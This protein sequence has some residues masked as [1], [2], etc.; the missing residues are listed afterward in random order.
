MSKITEAITTLPADKSKIYESSKITAH[1]LDG[2][3]AM[4]GIVEGIRTGYL[5]NLH[6]TKEPNGTFI[7]H[8]TLDEDNF[9]EVKD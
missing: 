4:R 3:E 2:R 8:M 9:H 5:D 6:L 1:D 7:L